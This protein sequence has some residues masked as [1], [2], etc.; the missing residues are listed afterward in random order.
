MGGDWPD[1]PRDAK[2]DECD[3]DE[4]LE[5]DEDYQGHGHRWVCKK[6]IPDPENPEDRDCDEPCCNVNGGEFVTAC[7]C[8]ECDPIDPPEPWERGP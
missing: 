6:P 4:H 2:C 3:S 8:P 5:L 7:Y 1:L